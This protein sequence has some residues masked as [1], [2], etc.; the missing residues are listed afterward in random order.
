MCVS[1]VSTKQGYLT[2]IFLARQL[3]IVFHL[4]SLAHIC[5]IS[6][7]DTLSTTLA[8]IY[9]TVR[10]ERCVHTVYTSVCV[11]KCV[12]QRVCIYVRKQGASRCLQVCVCAGWV[13]T[14]GGVS[15]S[16]LSSSH[17]KATWARCFLCS[18][19]KEG[20]K[21]S[22]SELGMPEEE[23]HTTHPLSSCTNLYAVLQLHLLNYI[24]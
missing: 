8:T 11:C 3:D 21:L 18:S 13:L 6:P 24:C 1:I 14:R 4:L 15:L 16:S 9:N 20:L 22:L 2:L 10:K 17:S 12:Y 19:H 5:I 7:S 23:T